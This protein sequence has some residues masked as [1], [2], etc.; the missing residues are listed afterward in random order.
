MVF[1]LSSTVFVLLG[2]GHDRVTMDPVA[3][4]LL[5]CVL[6]ACILFVGVF[7]AIAILVASVPLT[8]DP[9]PIGLPP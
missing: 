2:R 8:P 4:R 9:S 5:M 3:F 7:L 6:G 1:R